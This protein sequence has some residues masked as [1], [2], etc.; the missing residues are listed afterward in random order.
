MTTRVLLQ[1]VLDPGNH[2][3]VLERAADKT[4]DEVKLLV[5]TLQ[6]RPAVPES[7]RRLPTRRVEAP[8]EPPSPLFAAPPP[9]SATPSAE[10]GSGHERNVNSPLVPVAVAAEVRRPKV[11]PLNATQHSIRFT[12]GSEFME[13]LTEARS[14]LS[15]VVPDGSLEGILRECMK[16]A[17]EACAK[18]QRG[19]TKDGG[20][21]VV[22]LASA[23]VQPDSAE[24]P[25]TR[26]NSKR[27]LWKKRSRY[28][29]AAVRRAVWK[30]DGGRCTFVGPD[31]TRCGSTH[32]LQLDH[33]RP[34]ALGGEST[35]E[36]LTLH[37]VAHN[38]LRAR[39]HFRPEH[40]AKFKRRSAVRN[41]ADDERSGDTIARGR[42]PQSP[43]QREAISRDRTSG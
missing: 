20:T 30:R 8:S 42:S 28:V 23:D 39:L 43:P 17:L 41:A 15:H 25:E 21:R 6:P 26:M 36:N 27:K 4:E 33:L 18:R 5:A 34:F 9:V 12:A 1:D 24:S 29:P 7:I 14:V 40:M 22:A 10:P 19:A 3:E 38:L 37:C 16:K 2:L 11:E 35:V 13:L 32:M 31:G